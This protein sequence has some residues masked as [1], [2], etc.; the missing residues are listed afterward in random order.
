MPFSIVTIGV[1]LMMSQC[2]DLHLTN[3]NTNDFNQRKFNLWNPIFLVIWENSRLWSIEPNVII[4]LQ[5]C[6]EWEF[7]FVQVLVR[8]VPPVP[9]K[10]TQE[11]VDDFFSLNHPGYLQTEVLSLPIPFGDWSESLS[12]LRPVSLNSP[13]TSQM[14]FNVLNLGIWLY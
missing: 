10:S 5:H 13:E 14:Q 7:V 9:G 3:D 1:S 2:M 8:Q 11:L 4:G 12:I 6:T